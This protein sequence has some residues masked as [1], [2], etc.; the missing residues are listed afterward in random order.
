MKPLDSSRDTADPADD[1]TALEST[2]DR[3]SENKDSI[4]PRRS[5]RRRRHRKSQS[6]ENNARDTAAPATEPTTEWTPPATEEFVFGQPVANCPNRKN[7]HHTCSPY[8]FMRWA[9]RPPEVTKRDVFQP[10]NPAFKQPP[11]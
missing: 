8:C 5:R 7:P 11:T 10:F 2:A 6:S 9:Q 4:E 1:G 3:E